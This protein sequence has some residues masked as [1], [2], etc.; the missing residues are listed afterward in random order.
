LVAQAHISYPADGVGL[1]LIDNPP[2]NFASWALI[3]R[4]EEAVYKVRDSGARVV[5][6]ASD[7]P[8][9][10]ICHAWLQEG[11]NTRQ[12]K[13]TSGDFLA[14]ARLG[15]ELINGPMVSIA[16]NHA[17]AWGGGSELSWCASL[18]TAGESATYAQI[19]VRIGVIAAG[20]GTS[21]L[22]R[23]IGEARAME[24]LLRGRPFT[25]QQALQWGAVNWVFPDATLREETIKIA[26][27]IAA[28]PNWAVQASKKSVVS[29]MRLLPRDAAMNEAACWGAVSDNPG[30]A[31][32][33][34]ETQARYD[35]GADSYEALGIPRD[36]REH[37]GLFL[38]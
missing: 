14:W 19:E 29:G 3:E 37:R 21:R 10:F 2:R 33:C 16:C 36:W 38:E 4:I 15:R 11:I 7:V 12:G 8:G 17:Q 5:V 18:R 9:Y 26:A 22:P 32:L 1:V 30:I 27:E 23:L 28:L 13:P 20:G 6:L 31:P 25:A 35:G 34:E 24:V